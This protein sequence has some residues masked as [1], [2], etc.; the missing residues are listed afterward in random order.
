MHYV[1]TYLLTYLL[2]YCRHVG[3]VTGCF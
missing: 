2:T 1:I 3:A